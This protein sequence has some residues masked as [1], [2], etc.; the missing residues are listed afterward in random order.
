M[1]EFASMACCNNVNTLGMPTVVGAPA[2]PEQWDWCG[3]ILDSGPVDAGH[4]IAYGPD[5]G[6]L[7]VFTVSARVGAGNTNVDAVG[8]VLNYVDPGNFFLVRWDDPNNAYTRTTKLEFIRC[9]AGQCA[10]LD[11]V[12][13]AATAA[14]AFTAFDVQ[15]RYDA[16]DVYTGGVL[17]MSTI[18]NGGDIGPGR[19]GVYAFDADTGSLVDSITVSQP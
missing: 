12:D 6:Q 4:S 9:V 11:S 7:N 3:G 8:I 17:R 5:L 10:V 14:L 19:V 15:V 18:T 2:D 16:I 1:V 13:P